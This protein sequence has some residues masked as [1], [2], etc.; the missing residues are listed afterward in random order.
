MKPLRGRKLVSWLVRGASGTKVESLPKSWSVSSFI[1]PHRR[2]RSHG[3]VNVAI[4]TTMPTKTTIFTISVGLVMFCRNQWHGTTVVCTL[5]EMF[6]IYTFIIR[7]S[8]WNI[9]FTPSPV[10]LRSFGRSFSALVHTVGVNNLKSMSAWPTMWNFIRA[11]KF[12]VNRVVDV[13]L[14]I[15]VKITF[16]GRD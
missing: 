7:N 11:T 6:F 3:S 9:N 10:S 16:L 14:Y 13:K 1:S 8:C 15:L 2:W 5:N 4:C 12:N